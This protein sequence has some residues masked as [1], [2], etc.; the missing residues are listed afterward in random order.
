MLDYHLHCPYS[1]NVVVCPRTKKIK[2]VTSIYSVVDFSPF[3]LIKMEGGSCV[4]LVGRL[5]DV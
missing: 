1:Q 2:H 4:R 3:L 5:L